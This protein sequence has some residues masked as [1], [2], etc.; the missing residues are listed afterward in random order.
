ME[1]IFVFTHDSIFL[2]EDGPTHQPVEQLAA[3]RA[4]PNLE[5]WRPADGIETAAAWAAGIERKEGPSLFAFTRQKLQPLQ[6]PRPADVAQILR[7]AYALHE[8]AEPGRGIV[9]TGSW[10]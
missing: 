8:G 6:R 9:A 4:I 10:R 1:S 5:V 3:L 2:G 7:A